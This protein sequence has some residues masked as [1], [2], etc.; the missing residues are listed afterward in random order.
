MLEG[1]PVI[2]DF[3]SQWS[4][5]FELLGPSLEDFFRF[6]GGKFSLKTVILLANQ[7]VTLLKLIHRKG[8][9]LREVIPHNFRMG[10]CKKYNIVHF[11]EFG[12]ADLLIDLKTNEHITFKNNLYVDARVATMGFASLNY[13]K[14][15]ELSKRDDLES[16]FY[17]LIYFLKGEL[18]WQNIKGENSEDTIAKVKEKMESTSVETLCKGLPGN[19]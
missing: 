8:V 14:G 19:S 13:I 11:S 1:I 5:Y 12:S 6:C 15:N 9:R 10:H 4:L 7:M 17:V 16:L 2:I 18:P 3:H